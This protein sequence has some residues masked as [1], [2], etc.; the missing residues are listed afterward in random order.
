MLESIIWLETVEFNRT[1]KVGLVTDEFIPP[2]ADLPLGYN[3][4]YYL[5]GADTDWGRP[6]S[7][8]EGRVVV[9]FCGTLFTSVKLPFKKGNDYFSIRGFYKVGEWNACYYHKTMRGD[10]NKFKLI[11][12]SEVFHVEA[13]VPPRAQRVRRKRTR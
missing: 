12:N 6:A 2:D 4:R 5:R 7:A 11:Y 9:N 8:E 3:Y 1:S 10:Q 13:E